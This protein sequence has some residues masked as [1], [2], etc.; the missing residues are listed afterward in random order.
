VFQQL[1]FHNLNYSSSRIYT[2]K[3]VYLTSSFS[4]AS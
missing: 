2:L 1:Q 4:F 3:D